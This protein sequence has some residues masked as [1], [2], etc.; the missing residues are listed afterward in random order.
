MRG[1]GGREEREGEDIEKIRFS[2]RHSLLKSKVMLEEGGGRREEKRRRKR[3]SEAEGT[4]RREGGK[5]K[6]WKKNHIQFAEVI[7]V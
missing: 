1:K 4:K 3:K 6:I 7:N 5:E 2:S